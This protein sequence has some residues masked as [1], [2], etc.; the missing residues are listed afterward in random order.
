MNDGIVSIAERYISNIPN[1]GNLPP[2]PIQNI[3]KID[4]KL[5]WKMIEYFL[6]LE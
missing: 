5:D 4:N 1:H 6:W 3:G 2:K